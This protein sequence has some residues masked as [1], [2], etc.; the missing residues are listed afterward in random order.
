MLIRHAETYDNPE[1]L[2]K[3]LRQVKVPTGDVRLR[4]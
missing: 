4:Q 3:R 1:G 2:A